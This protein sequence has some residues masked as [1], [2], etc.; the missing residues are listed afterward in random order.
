[1]MMLEMYLGGMIPV[2]LGKIYK[3]TSSG[4]ELVNNNSIQADTWFPNKSWSSEVL[5]V[6][7]VMP[8]E[9]ERDILKEK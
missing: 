3:Q 2:V 7:T 6:S 9:E 1:M 4:T 5:A 8:I